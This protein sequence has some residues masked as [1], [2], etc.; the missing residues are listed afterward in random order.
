[1][2]AGSFARV[3][4]GRIAR[5]APRAG[6]STGIPTRRFSYGQGIKEP[7]MEQSFGTDPCFPGNPALRAE[8]SR[9][10][11]A[12]VEQLFAADRVRVSANYFDNRFRD[13]ISFAFNPVSTPACPFGL[14]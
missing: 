1:M 5:A 12:G 13:I 3:R 8:R 2:R 9:T 6:S 7:E 14:G 11:N 4:T 10:I